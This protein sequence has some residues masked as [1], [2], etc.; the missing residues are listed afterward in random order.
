MHNSQTTELIE[1][2]NGNTITTSNVRARRND[3]N[4]N[5][6]IAINS[7]DTEERNDDYGVADRK[8]VV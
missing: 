8:S 2:C 5:N 4:K 6:N 1:V 3:H 7:N